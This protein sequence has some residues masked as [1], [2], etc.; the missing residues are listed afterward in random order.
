MQR[1]HQVEGIRLPV[2][3][4]NT[5]GLGIVHK[6]RVR[7]VSVLISA[8]EGFSEANINCTIEQGLARARAVAKEARSLNMAVRG[9]VSKHYQHKLRLL[10]LSG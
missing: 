9:Y 2:L 4:P 1:L 8:T 3:V 7:E 6:C 5:R 10:L